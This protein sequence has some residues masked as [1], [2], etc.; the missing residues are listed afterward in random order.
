VS[1]RIAAARDL[2]AA[3]EARAAKAKQTAE[4]TVKARMAEAARGF[5]STSSSARGNG[6]LN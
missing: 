5:S 6:G 1:Q 2:K 4:D 3:E